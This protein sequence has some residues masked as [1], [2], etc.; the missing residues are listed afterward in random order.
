M[1]NLIKKRMDAVERLNQIAKENSPLRVKAEFISCKACKSRLAKSYLRQKGMICV[2][3]VCNASLFS[4]T[5]K[6]RMEKTREKIKELD[7]KIEQERQIAAWKESE[8]KPKN[9]FKEAL[10][11]TRDRFDY[12]MEEYKT[13][14]FVELIGKIGGDVLAFRVYNNGDVY[15]K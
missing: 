10:E 4:A 1:E 7:R 8:Q 11:E 5:A 12:I 13:P 2:C 3:P 15:E 6:E 9:A 14:D